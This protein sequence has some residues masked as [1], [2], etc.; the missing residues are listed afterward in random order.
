M[1]KSFCQNYKRA[2]SFVLIVF[3]MF[4]NMAAAASAK[5]DS[6]PAL[7][8]DLYGIYITPGT[9]ETLDE[10]SIQLFCEDNSIAFETEVSEDVL[11]ITTDKP[12]LYKNYW[13][14]SKDGNYNGDLR[15]VKRQTALRTGL[16]DAVCCFFAGGDE[17]CFVIYLKTACFYQIG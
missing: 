4:V 16:S 11:K 14:N 10:N 3:Y 13:C 12:E 9:G 5:N 15:S 7:Y 17:L 2:L 8:A 1:N 6:M